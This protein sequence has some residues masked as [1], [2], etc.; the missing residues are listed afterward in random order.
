MEAIATRFEALEAIRLD[1]I[2]TRFEALEAIR[3]EGI[4]TRLEAIATSNKK[5]LVARSY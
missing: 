2:A 5:V 3:L 1:S 4:A